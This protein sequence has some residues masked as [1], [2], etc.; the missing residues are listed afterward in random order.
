MCLFLTAPYYLIFWP[1]EDSVSVVIR[2]SIVGSD[3]DTLDVGTE[4]QVKQRSK[5]FSG[6]VAASGEKKLIL[7]CSIGYIINILS[8]RIQGFYA[9]IRGSVPG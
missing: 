7:T 5:L 8:G 3:F 9:S 2:S 4:C 6:K 1:E